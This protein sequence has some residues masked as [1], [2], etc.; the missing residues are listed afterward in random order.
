MPEWLVNHLEKG[1]YVKAEGNP[2]IGEMGETNR[3]ALLTDSQGIIPVLAQLFEQ[4]SSTKQAY[5]CHPS[6]NH[7]SKLKKE[8]QYSPLIRKSGVMATNGHNMK[9]VSA[10]IATYKC[11][12]RILLA[13]STQATTIFA[14]GSPRSLISKK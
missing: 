11:C 12:R 1:L 2:H 7:V 4:C 8:G 13:P 9:A 3:S 14:A 6:T 5:L 10:A